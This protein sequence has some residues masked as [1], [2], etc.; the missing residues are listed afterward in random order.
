[1]CGLSEGMGKDS[2][3]GNAGW[4]AN[5]DARRRRGI[6]AA[7]IA[8]RRQALPPSRGNALCFRRYSAIHCRRGGHTMP[9]MDDAKKTA[10]QYRNGQ[11]D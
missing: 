6:A 11:S 9:G 7:I 3:M 5:V 2:I 8:A 4:Q 1:M 10:G